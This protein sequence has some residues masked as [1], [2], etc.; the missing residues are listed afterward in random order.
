VTVL[1]RC[2]RFDLRRIEPEDQIDRC[3]RSRPLKSAKSPMTLALIT[4]AAEGCP[5]AM[6]N[7]CWIRRSA[8]ARAKP[9]PI[10]SAQC[11]DWRW[12]RARSVRHDP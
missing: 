7:H 1:S 11:W 5:H 2:Q 10:R 4:R 9:L 8:M 12:T 6:R 3:A